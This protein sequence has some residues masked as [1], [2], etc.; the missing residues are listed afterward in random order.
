MADRV[1]VVLPDEI[2]LAAVAEGAR[3]DRSAVRA[4]AHERLARFVDERAER[5]A[6]DRPPYALAGRVVEDVRALVTAQHFRR[7]RRA[8]VAPRA[9]LRQRVGADRP[10][11]EILRRQR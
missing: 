10:V 11:D 5:F 1:S 6:R 3:V 9:D 7:P 2:E 4:L 8:V